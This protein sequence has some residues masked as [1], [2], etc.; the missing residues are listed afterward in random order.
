MNINILFFY[1]T[2]FCALLVSA[3]PEYIK[4]IHFTN[5]NDSSQDCWRNNKGLD[6][7]IKIVKSLGFNYI[8]IP[9]SLTLT[10]IDN[11][12]VVCNNENIKVVINMNEASIANS[13]YQ[14]EHVDVGS[15]KIK[16][17]NDEIQK[18]T[19]SFFFRNP[20][21]IIADNKTLLGMIRDESSV[22]K[23]TNYTEETDPRKN[24][25]FYV[26][27]ETLFD[28]NDNN[29]FVLL[30]FFQKNKIK[31]S[32]LWFYEVGQRGIFDSHDCNI[33]DF[34]KNSNEY[35]LFFTFIRNNFN[36][37]RN[38]Q[39]YAPGSPNSMYSTGS[40]YSN[41]LMNSNNIV[42]I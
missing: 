31:N 42:V 26:D 1:L 23:I 28:K 36:I 29:F 17:I 18:K 5:F 15:E 38:L 40:I 21:G 20:H 33:L 22:L 11:F 13:S 24:L 35:D 34:F 4:G 3:S 41:L 6:Y 30:D 14:E 37:R 2:Q 12:L 8:T 9:V 7:H 16:K 39:L 32:F 19:S 10:E 25:L 27:K